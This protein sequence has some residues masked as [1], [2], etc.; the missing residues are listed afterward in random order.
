MLDMGIV[1]ML[2]A[3]TLNETQSDTQPWMKEVSS[4][5]LLQAYL[6]NCIMNAAIRAM[7]VY[8]FQDGFG[9]IRF[10]TTFIQILQ[11]Y[12]GFPGMK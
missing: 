9:K 10:K 5:I 2:P 1:I 4:H 12:V 7:F 6:Q 8:A 11:E 3:S